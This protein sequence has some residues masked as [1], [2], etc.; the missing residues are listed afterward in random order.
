MIWFGREISNMTVTDV[1]IDY[2][3][4]VLQFGMAEQLEKFKYILELWK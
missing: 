1:Y 4:L 3:M 2:I